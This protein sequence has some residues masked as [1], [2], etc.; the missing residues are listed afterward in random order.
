[1]I[2]THTHLYLNAFNN[3][4]EEVVA[5]A[6]ADGVKYM[7]LPNIDSSSVKGMQAL[8]DR[9]PENCFPMMGLHPTSVKGNFREELKMVEDL[10]ASNNYF[11]VGETGIDLYWDKTWYREQVE[12]F[13]RQIDLAIAYDLPLIIH[14]RES[15]TEIFRVLENRDTGGLRGVFHCFTGDVGQAK[16]AT[17]LDFK[18]G[19]GGVL[20]YKNS[21]LDQVVSEIGLNELILETDAP[22]LSPVPHRGK[23]NESAYV[24][25]VAEKLSEIL[26]ISI[27]EVAEA[28]T[29][30]ASE[31]FNM[32][33]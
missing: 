17:A 2:D 15:F 3:D 4:R 14:A 20:T 19:I 1:M 32:N 6:L 25:H 16:H 23:R 8:C 7:L 5:R 9:F 13:N 10:L 12:A 33:I 26:N 30:N 18:L 22:Y 28:T 31:L 11:G 27:E 29:H 21:G 24:L